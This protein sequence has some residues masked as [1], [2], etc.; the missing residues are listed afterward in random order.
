MKEDAFTKKTWKEV[1]DA[2]NETKGLSLTSVNTLFE[3]QTLQE[4]SKVCSDIV[5]LKQT[6]N[7][8]TEEDNSA[9]QKAK[10]VEDQRV[11]V[12][13]KGR[14]KLFVGAIV[15]V[16]R[17]SD[18]EVKYD[19]SYLD[20]DSEKDVPEKWITEFVEHKVGELVEARR[21]GNVYNDFELAEV[22]KYHKDTATYD[23]QYESD[24]EQEMGVTRRIGSRYDG[25]QKERC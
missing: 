7:E 4:I 2:L 1:L 25:D 9:P 3:S 12:R 18:G 11:L 8:K 14:N 5:V 23:L 19:V 13:F 6:E 10:F 17:T 15:S 24:K 22:L 20:G 21:H 16:K